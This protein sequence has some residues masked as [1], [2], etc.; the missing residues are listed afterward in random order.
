MSLKSVHVINWLD[1]AERLLRK[2]DHYTQKAIRSEFA[3]DP[4]KDAI[5]ID[6]LRH[7]FVTPVSDRRFVVIWKWDA[8]DQKSI[9]VQAVVPSQL[10]SR[11]PEEIR[12]Q[13]S[14]LV[15]LETNGALSLY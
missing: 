1:A 11:D 8:S 5:E 14:E 9:E 6:N 15:R 12:E 4:F 7:H 2:R 3:A 13:V 10:I